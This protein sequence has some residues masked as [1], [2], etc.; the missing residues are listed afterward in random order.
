MAALYS[1][2]HERATTLLEEGRTSFEDLRDTQ[3]AGLC[4]T[5]LWMAT[6]EAG[7]RKRAAALL[8]ENLR[9]SLGLEVLPRVQ[10][11]DD[12]MGSAAVAVLEGRTD[13]SARLLGAAETLR[14][15]IN[16]SLL[17]WDHTPTDYAGLFAAT[18]SRLGEAAWAEAWTKGRDMAPEEAVEYAL[19]ADEPALAPE[20]AVASPL[21]GREM[22][23]LA[24]MAE[25]LT[26]PQ[27]AGRLYL[28]P[29]TVGQHLRSIYR[30]LGVSSRAAAAREAV[31]RGLI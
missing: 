24:L 6:L 23:V 4:L 19:E 18:R 11:Y 29:R 12:L 20:D 9:R 25:G 26:N 21:S 17:L 22:E 30:K 13:R 16:L 3:R 10:T 27:I 31:E 14:V 15:T 1:G 7:E 5:Y 8:R 28:S 2:D